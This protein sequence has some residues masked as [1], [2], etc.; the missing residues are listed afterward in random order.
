M[1]TEC[2]HTLRTTLAVRFAV[3]VVT[4]L[5]PDSRGCTT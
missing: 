3:S 5:G 1:I 4:A 2:V